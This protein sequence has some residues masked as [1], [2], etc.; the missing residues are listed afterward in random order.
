MSTDTRIN[1]K[2]LNAARNGDEDAL[3]ALVER[4]RERLERVVL[5]RMDRRLQFVKTHASTRRITW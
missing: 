2:L 3:A 5:L 1:E 4:H